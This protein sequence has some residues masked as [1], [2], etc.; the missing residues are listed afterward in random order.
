MLFVIALL[1]QSPGFASEGDSAYGS[2]IQLIDKLYLHPEQ[3]DE[4]RVVAHEV[5]RVHA[6]RPGGFGYK[7]G[8]AVGRPAGR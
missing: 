4:A 2:A 3:V 6:L 8:G 7:A 5:L 1:L